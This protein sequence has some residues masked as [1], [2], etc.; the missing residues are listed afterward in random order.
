[1][2]IV[3]IGTNN[4]KDHVNKFA[5]Y[6]NKY[7]EFVLLVE[8]LEELNAEIYKNYDT[9][10]NVYLENVVISNEDGSC[11]FNVNPDVTTH[12]SLDKNHLLKCNHKEENIHQYHNDV[13]NMSL[14]NKYLDNINNFLSSS[15]TSSATTSSTTSFST[16]SSASTI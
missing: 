6:F 10:K 5:K 13:D 15:T 1:M 14:V 9:I 2:K 16:T 11:I 8:P 7:L 12:S 4:G 3:Q